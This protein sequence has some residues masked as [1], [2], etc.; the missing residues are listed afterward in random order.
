VRTNNEQIFK[1]S[2]ILSGEYQ[3]L[4]KWTMSLKFLEVVK[5][6]KNYQF[7]SK[8]AA[9]SVRLNLLF[10]KF[11]YLFGIISPSFFHSSDTEPNITRKYRKRF[12]RN[13]RFIGAVVTWIT[14]MIQWLEMQHD[15]FPTDY[16]T[17]L[18][19]YQQN[20]SQCINLSVRGTQIW[21]QSV[22]ECINLCDV[23]E[24][25]SNTNKSI[26]NVLPKR[27]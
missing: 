27:S 3:A 4:E 22:H 13:K 11:A 17:L 9:Q 12:T 20:I 24:N 23:G 26:I 5:R 2:I 21:V 18:F 25:F 19:I 10:H 1:Q 7:M 16:F 8:Y 15:L 14:Q 6:L